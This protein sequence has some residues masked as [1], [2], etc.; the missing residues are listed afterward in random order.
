MSANRI[1]RFGL[2]MTSCAMSRALDHGDW[3]GDGKGRL[4]ILRM[5]LESY[6]QIRPNQVFP[7]HIQYVTLQEQPCQNT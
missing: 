5:D 2:C 7:D 4:I 6:K 1:N 3:R